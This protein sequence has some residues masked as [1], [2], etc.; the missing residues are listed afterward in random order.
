[1]T[2]H[3]LPQLWQQAEEI[4]GSPP[5]AVLTAAI[6]D[7]PESGAQPA[8]DTRVAAGFHWSSLWTAALAVVGA[9]LR[10]AVAFSPSGTAAPWTSWQSFSAL[11]ACSSA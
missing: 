6:S 11:P 5:T 8:A 7:S 1:M 3:L 4:L 9:E 10:E 2:T